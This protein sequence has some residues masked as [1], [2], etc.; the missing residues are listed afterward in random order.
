MTIF[1]LFVNDRLVVVVPVARS[2]DAEADAVADAAVMLMRRREPVKE[3]ACV[4]R[5][6]VVGFRTS[7]APR[8]RRSIIV[9]RKA[10]TIRSMPRSLAPSLRHPR[11]IMVCAM[12]MMLKEHI[13]TRD[14]K[15]E[16]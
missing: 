8:W 11:K 1:D 5:H 14:Q 16:I 10:G 15:S 9:R 3:D 13:I 12:L 2:E 7:D 6:D 4:W